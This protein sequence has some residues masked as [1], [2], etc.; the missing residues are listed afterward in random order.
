MTTL[1]RH[2]GRHGRLAGVFEVMEVAAATATMLAALVA[3]LPLVLF[4]PHPHAG[5]RR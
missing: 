4:P 2:G 3:S 5:A 1:F